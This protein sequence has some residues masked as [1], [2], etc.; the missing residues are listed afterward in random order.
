MIGSV[1][2]AT[3]IVCRVILGAGEGPAFSVAV[4]SVFKWFP[5]HQRTLPTA[6]LSQG[7]AVAKSQPQAHERRAEEI[8]DACFQD[9]ANG[10]EYSLLT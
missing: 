6:I 1:G 5:D 8:A 9:L 2:F 10:R 7:A 4:H 3:L